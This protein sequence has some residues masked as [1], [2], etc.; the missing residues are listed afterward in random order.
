M[1]ITSAANTFEI[2]SAGAGPTFT[3][4]YAVHKAGDIKVYVGGAVK[5]PGDGDYP[6][7]V[8]VA[9]NKESADITFTDTATTPV[10]GLRLIFERLL[11]YKQET[12]L[13]NNSLFDAESLETALDNIVMQVQQVGNVA[14]EEGSTIVQ[15]DAGLGTGYDMYETNAQNASTI[16]KLKAA[17]ANKALAFDNLG[18]ITVTV[19]DI[20]DAIDYQ[21]EAEEWA[22][23]ASGNVFSYTDGSRDADQGAISAKAQATA[24]AGSAT[25]S[26]ASFASFEIRYLGAFTTVARENAP[27]IGLDKE[28]A[29]LI[30]GAMYFDTTLDVMKVWD[31]GGSQWIQIKPTTGE[32]TSITTVV[33]NP[34][35][36]NIGLV[37]AIDGNVTSVAG[38]DANVTTV[39]GISGNVTTVAG[40]S[41]NTTTVA[42]ISSDVTSV[43]GISAAVTAVNGDAVDIGKV[44]A[45]DSNVTSVAAIDSNVTT[46]AGIAADV[47]SVAGD[48]TDI[49]AVATIDTEVGVVAGIASNITTVATAPIPANLAIVAPIAANVTTVA[50]V[51]GNV[52]TVAGISSD[53]TVVAGDVT[54]IGTVAGVSANVTTVAGISANTTTVAGIS[55]NVTTVAGVS[56]DVTTVADNLTNIDN[57]KDLYQIST[58]SP[59]PSLD[60]GGNAIAEGDLA[61]DSTLNALK[62]CNG[63]GPVTFANVSNVTEVSSDTSPQLGGDLDLNGWAVG[64]A[65][66]IDWTGTITGSANSFLL[67]K[68]IELIG[69]TTLSGDIY[70]AT[71]AGDDVNITGNGFTLT[72]TGSI[73]IRQILS[74]S[75]WDTAY[76]YSQVTHLPLAGGTMSA[77]ADISTSTTGK[78][79]QKG[80]FMQSSTHQA[81]TLGG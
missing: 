47:T 12:D 51:S 77:G 43:A 45:I 16:S 42:L 71:V 32:Q 7:G 3:Y 56:A 74:S 36:T 61:Y 40:I 76:T 20:E 66:T 27:N 2:A 78:V 14:T 8:V 5:L 39:A 41:G 52:T 24:S 80:A 53:V 34:L 62:I 38:I 48:A 31:Y 35:K 13:A 60:G 28:G 64:H 29:A 23:L 54:D 65:T 69:N 79:K 72:G 68:D 50:G 17:R 30:D 15:F 11:E 49:G 4:P 63:I 22:S 25:N 18:N 57:F 81:L 59:A 44:A 58:F 67:G 1:T 55:A 70:F 9:A 46:V 6:Y 26:A 10:T 21:L 37:A 33:T 75:D 73:D 19:T